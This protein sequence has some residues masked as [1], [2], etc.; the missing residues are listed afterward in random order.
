MS[1][2]EK[3]VEQFEE[4]YKK[5]ISN[6]INKICSI[7]T[8][9]IIL[10]VRNAGITEQVIDDIPNVGIRLNN[11]LNELSQTFNKA[12]ISMYS[13]KAED[14]DTVTSSFIGEA[15]IIDL[16]EHLSQ[17]TKK[18]EEYDKKSQTI[19]SK[20]TQ[21]SRALTTVNTIKRFFTKIKYLFTIV[22]PTDMTLTEEEKRTL[23]EPLDEFTDINDKIWKYNLK[24]NVI[25]SI[26][27]HIHN[28][29]YAAFTVPD[30][31]EECVI[32]DLQ[33][34]GLD[35][36]IPELQ[37]KLIEVYKRD[38]LNLKICEEEMGIYVPNF[39]K[40]TQNNP[41]SEHDDNKVQTVQ[42][43]TTEDTLKGKG[44]TKE[45]L[46]VI[47]RIVNSLEEGQPTEII[48]QEDR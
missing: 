2:S 12:G 40:E 3:R 8:E 37:S 41:Q 25:D 17:A 44:I 30:L 14:I 35:D 46:D 9:N 10:T 39:N 21:Q 22:S 18:L 48:E 33:N 36:L 38:A 5:A 13:A 28:T 27:K 16:I 31:L 26:V 47:G 15:I 4:E 6:R 32:P 24:D 23:K 43:E 19:I 42:L 29:G 1:I 7:Q 34:L 11:K 20:K 45:E